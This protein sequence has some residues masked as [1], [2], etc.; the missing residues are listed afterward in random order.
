MS[1]VTTPGRA[2]KTGTKAR[3]ASAKCSSPQPGVVPSARRTRCGR[4]LAAGAAGAVLVVMVHGRVQPD[5]LARR[6]GSVST[7]KADGV[8]GA[9]AGRR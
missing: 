8:P 5:V 4:A 3:R 1:E 9:L 6:L 2:A 7:P